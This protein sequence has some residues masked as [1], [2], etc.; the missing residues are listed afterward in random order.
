VKGKGKIRIKENI[1]TI[2]PSL[3]LPRKRGPNRLPRQSDK[4]RTWLVES[5]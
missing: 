5:D 3:P 4:N 1:S 2:E